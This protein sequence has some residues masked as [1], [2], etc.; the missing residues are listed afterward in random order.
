[1]SSLAEQI[2]TLVLNGDL[3]PGDK[4]DEQVLAERFEVSRTPVREALRQLA[5]TGLIEL[6]PRRGAYVS[7]LTPA[8]R[9]EIFIAMTELEA[10]CSRLAAMSMAPHERR[11]LRRMHETMGELASRGLIE[12]FEQ[13]NETLH[14]MISKGAHNEVLSDLTNS[15]RE[16]LRPNRNIQF[17]SAG[18]LSRAHAEHEAIVQAIVSGDPAK[19]HA[20]MLHHLGQAG[21]TFKEA[22]SDQRGDSHVPPAQ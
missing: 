14:D 10:T 11:N 6:R 2:R 3:S 21:G 7:A 5:S 1:M 15:L 19:A 8:Q 12:E 22:L 9:E 18:R 17:G 13:A 4:L 16:R 20:S